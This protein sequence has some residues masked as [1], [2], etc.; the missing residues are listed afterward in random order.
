MTWV[1]HTA[2]ILQVDFAWMISA[3]RALHRKE[4]GE[5]Q[6][7]SSWPSEFANHRELGPGCLIVTGPV[8]WP[9]PTWWTRSVANQAEHHELN[10]VSQH[11]T[12]STNNE[13][14]GT[15]DFHTLLAALIGHETHLSFASPLAGC[16]MSLTCHKAFIV[17]SCHVGISGS[18]HRCCVFRNVIPLQWSHIRWQTGNSGTLV[19]TLRM[20]NS[21]NLPQPWQYKQNSSRKIC[22]EMLRWLICLERCWYWR[23]P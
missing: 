10:K 5:K 8:T 7:N 12:C 14:P 6:P 9:V 21:P 15:K 3:L 13:A 11:I 1:C 18:H 20:G 19:Q 4:N 23:F 2:R 16:W 22:S 17:C